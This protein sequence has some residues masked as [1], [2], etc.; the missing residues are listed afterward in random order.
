M[1]RAGSNKCC[2]SLGVVPVVL[3]VPVVADVPAVHVVPVVPVVLAVPVIP[4][5]LYVL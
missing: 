4:E 1:G 2:C 3:A 5:C